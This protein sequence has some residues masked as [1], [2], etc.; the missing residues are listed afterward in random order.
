MKSL[1]SALILYPEAES[2]STLRKMTL[3]DVRE[4]RR[5]T[6]FEAE[7]SGWLYNFRRPRGAERDLSGLS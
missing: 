1:C 5:V 4:Y 2:D 6:S 7:G 3:R